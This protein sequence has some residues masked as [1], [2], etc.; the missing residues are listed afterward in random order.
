MEDDT[1]ICAKVAKL[2]FFWRKK[3]ENEAESYPIQCE[4]ME[5]IQRNVGRGFCKDDERWL[6]SIV[7][8]MREFNE[9][10]EKERR[11]R[12]L[13]LQRAGGGAGIGYTPTDSPSYKRGMREMQ[14]ST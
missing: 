12:Y 4:I 9:K 2:I 3:D 14:S 8:E 6:A 11:E 13:E 10:K 1:K 7:D 5:L